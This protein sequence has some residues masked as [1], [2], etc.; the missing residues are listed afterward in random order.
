MSQFFHPVG[1]KD[2]NNEVKFALHQIVCSRKK[3]ETA[4]R[5]LGHYDQFSHVVSRKKALIQ[6]TYFRLIAASGN[7]Y[8]DVYICIYIFLPAT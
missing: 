8:K 7:L 4:Y 2:K 6:R 3:W 1:R 5:L